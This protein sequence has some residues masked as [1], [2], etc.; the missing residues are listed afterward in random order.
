MIHILRSSRRALIVISTAI[1]TAGFAL[2]QQAAI[3]GKLEGHTSPVY[4]VAWRP[5]GK[6]LATAGF[7]NTIRLWDAATRKQIKKLEGHTKL[8]LAVAISPDGKLILS[9]SQDNTAKI[10]DWPVF[11][12]TR[13]FAGSPG[14]VQALAVKPD[15]KQAAVA[16]GKA[17]KVWDLASGQ[18]IKELQGHAGD[19]Q[20][21]G[22][23]W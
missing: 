15:G 7:D 3:V 8:V 4:S 6:S 2:A 16:A 23:A 21:F 22:M 20:L 18:P 11:S 10:W 5:D 19:V 12:P 1:L 17:I 13:T 14:P 9:G